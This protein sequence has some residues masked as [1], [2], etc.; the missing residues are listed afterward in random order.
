MLRIG[1]EPMIS[2]AENQESLPLDQRSICDA[3][4]S[5][6]LAL[7]GAPNATKEKV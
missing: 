2:L 7:T 3:S 6:L 4:F 1:F 5:R